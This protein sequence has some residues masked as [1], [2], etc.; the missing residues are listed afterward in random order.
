[1]RF[2]IGCAALFLALPLCAREESQAPVRTYNLLRE[3]DDWSFLADPSLRSDFWDPIKYVPLGCEACYVSLGGEIRQ[4]FEHVANDNWGKQPYPNTFLL[5]RYMLHSDWHLGKN[6]RIFVQLKSGLEDFRTGGPR[7]IDEKRLD[8]EA[9]LSRSA[10]RTKR[11]GW[12]CESG[13]RN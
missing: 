7:T 6:L 2:V 5:Q 8:F 3:N 10:T 1:M 11:T 4:V 9:P 12:C 13:G